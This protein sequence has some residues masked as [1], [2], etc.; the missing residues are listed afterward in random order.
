MPKPH[1]NLAVIVLHMQDRYARN[2]RAGG[3]DRMLPRQLEV[4]ARCAELD[5]RLW[6]VGFKPDRPGGATLPAIEE[7]V[8][9]VPRNFCKGEGRLDAFEYAEGRAFAELL[10]GEGIDTLYFMGLYAGA[11]VKENVRTASEH[12]FRVATHGSVV[13][14]ILDGTY[15]RGVE[16][17]AGLAEMRTF[18]ELLADL[19]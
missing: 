7:A 16:T 4:V 10:R 17:L 11:C 6:L 8:R 13:E 1:E 9:A 18:E 3:M 12:G 15:E 5:I 2:V 19:A 14:A